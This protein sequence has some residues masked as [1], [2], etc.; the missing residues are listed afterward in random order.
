M[1][2]L[3]DIAGG[4]GLTVSKL[5]QRIEL[6]LHDDNLS[7]AVR[8]FVLDDFCAQEAAQTHA[9]GNGDATVSM[10]ISPVTAVSKARLKRATTAS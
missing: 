3:A 8:V 7:L 6:E 10:S 4:Q 5:V 1:A 9:A 2:P